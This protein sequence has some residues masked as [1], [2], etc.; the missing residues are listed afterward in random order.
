MIKGVFSIICLHILKGC[1]EKYRK[2]LHEDEYYFFNNRYEVRNG[3]LVKVKRDDNAYS[4]E[5]F[6]KNVT[7]QAVVGKNGCGKSSLFEL[8]YRIINNFSFVAITETYRATAEP[9]YFIRNIKAE[10]FYE[11]DGGVWCIRCDDDTV[12][13]IREDE[14][15]VT[16]LVF[17]ISKNF[18]DEDILNQFDETLPGKGRLYKYEI[19]NVQKKIIEKTLSSFF[20]TL[21]IN[22]SIQSL[23]PCDYEHEDAYGAD[24]DDKCSDSWLMSLYE[25]NDG[26]MVPIGFEPYRG[27]NVLDLRNLKELTEDR[28]CA[29]LIDCYNKN[30]K[31]KDKKNKYRVLP[32]YDL[33]TI[34]FKLDDSLLDKKKYKQNDVTKRLVDMVEDPSN[35]IIQNFG[36][37]YGIFLADEEIEDSSA[38]K[39]G[40]IYLIRK[41][42]QICEKYPKY[43][44][45]KS[46]INNFFDDE[47][48]FK[49]WENWSDL[50][51][52]IKKILADNSHIAIKI[53]Q[54]VN[55]LKT[56][57]RRNSEDLSIFYT[58]FSYFD[59]IK[60]CFEEKK[61][62]TSIS[63]ILEHF[64]PSIFTHTIY[65]KNDKGKTGIEFSKLSS[66]ER[67]YVY[68]TSAY[69]YHLSNIISI[70][71][72]K[73][74][75]Q[76]HNVCLMLDEIELCFHPEYQRTFID[77]LLKSLKQYQV[78]KKVNVCILLTTHSPFVL[79]DIPQSNIL[80]LNNHGDIWKNEDFNPFGAN[81]NDLLA[82]SFFLEDGFTGEFARNKIM[83]L[84][85]EIEKKECL[86]SNSE[87]IEWQIQN[88]GEPVIREQLLIMYL[89]NRF[90]NNQKKKRDW[91]QQL[92]QNFE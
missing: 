15:D 62:F 28:I 16:K 27:K 76:Y 43:E 39:V 81:V 71:G 68:T 82:N 79:S 88:I 51:E 10:L 57:S 52:L 60:T 61:I 8:I 63:D 49:N 35:I 18:E 65:L 73:E 9:L 48:D 34:K 80:M 67:Q 11:L 55:F 85:D 1:P 19:Q 38:Y 44:K 77:N 31:I 87:K 74:R 37:K 59:Y 21:A 3:K 64:P 17:P 2:V 83:N 13:L 47:C 84:I 30:Q 40:L 69:L 90:G 22:Y 54:V 45:F 70:H 91:L 42:F 26:Y 4:R 46:L 20:Y 24:D 66:G 23:N 25:K 56:L 33:D 50:E 14:K 29:L 75:I 53:K 72:D 12:S 32:N 58:E 41:T 7:I 78:D 92:I 36:R 89:E 5:F 86:P 6:G